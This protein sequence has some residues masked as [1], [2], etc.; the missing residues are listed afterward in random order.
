MIPLIAPEVVA[1]RM[2]RRVLRPPEVNPHCLI[3][4]DSGSGKDFLVRR[5]ILG[6]AIPFARA[7]VLDVTRYHQAPG[8]LGDPTWAGW[9]V[10]VGEGGERASLP[11]HLDGGRYRVLV[12][13][14]E[15]ARTVVTDALG[16][17]DAVG[18][19]VLVVSDAGRITEPPNRGGLGL[20][21]QLSKLLQE[22]RRRSITVIVC[23][24]STNYLERGAAT[25]ART[26]LLGL[27]S[28]AEERKRFTEQAGLDGRQYTYAHEAL[29]RL[30]PRQF[31]YIDWCDGL[32]AIARTSAGGEV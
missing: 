7:I 17:V 14:G 15:A 31:I 29:A 13:P 25:Q 19:V 23:S 9:G 6:R 28:T 5:L 10:D 24:T 16:L 21:G 8:V 18:E 1:G 2:R 32:P 3:L 11:A 4:G 22:G 26:K 20:G 12:P 27:T 30:A